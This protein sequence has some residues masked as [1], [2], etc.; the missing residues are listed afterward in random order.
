[1]AAVKKDEMNHDDSGIGMEM[2]HEELRMTNYDGFVDIGVNEAS[3]PADVV[4]C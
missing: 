1:M 4:V 3:D 2:E